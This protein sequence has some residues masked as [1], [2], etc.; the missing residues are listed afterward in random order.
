MLVGEMGVKVPISLRINPDVDANTHP[1]ISTGLKANKFG[2]PHTSN[3]YYGMSRLNTLT[4]NGLSYRFSID[5]DSAVYDA[6]DRLLGLIDKLAEKTSILN[7]LM[8]VRSRCD[9]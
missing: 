8:W 1:H 9:L 6:L 3:C 5:R 4:S 2:I 7:I